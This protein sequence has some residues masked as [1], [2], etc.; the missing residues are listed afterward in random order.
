MQ[1]KDWLKTKESSL[2]SE[3]TDPDKL[4]SPSFRPLPSPPAP[5]EDWCWCGA[6]TNAP[7]V[8]RKA[9]EKM[10]TPIKDPIGMGKKVGRK[11]VLSYI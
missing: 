10:P 5:G 4:F 7:E 6:P 11:I 8:Y 3:T 1:F 2:R 9:N